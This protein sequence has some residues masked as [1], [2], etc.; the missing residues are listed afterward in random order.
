MRFQIQKRG[1]RRVEVQPEFEQVGDDK[2]I[3]STSLLGADGRRQERFQ[4]ITLR[5]GKIADMQGFA[6][7]RA[8]ERFAHR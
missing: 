7:R 2:I 3:S 6:S 8:A 5:D 4:V 1:Q